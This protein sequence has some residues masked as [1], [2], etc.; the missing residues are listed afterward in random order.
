M[1]MTSS[2]LHFL[3]IAEATRLIA[4]RELSPV[5]L[6]EAYLQRIALIDSQLQSFVTL[7][8]DLARQRAAA[9][10]AEIMRDGPR[11]RLHGIPYCLKDI[12]ETAGIRTTA[13]SKLLADRVPARD[14]VVAEKLAAAGGV[15]LGKTAT[16]EFAHGGPSW[17]VLFPPARNPWNTSHHPAGS[18]SGSGA[19]VA[20]GLAPATIG[21]DTGG[22]IRGPAAACGI[23]GIKPTYGLVSRRGVLP[24]CFS[25]DHVGPLAWTSEDVAILLSIVAGHDPADPG[26]ADVP[27]KDY[28]TGLDAGIAGLV[29]GVPWRWLEEEAPLTLETR[30]GFDAA[31]A[32]FRDLGAEI[33]AVEP[34]PMQLF[35]DAKKVIAM[36]ELYSIH[37]KDLKTRPEL[38]GDSLRYRIIAGGLIRAEDY[39]QA[40]RVRRD[41]AIALQQVFATIDLMLLPT[42]E[43]AEK[44]EPVPHSSLFTGPSYMTAFNVGGNPA[45]SVCSGF[46]ANGMPQSLQ[47]AGRLFDDG[48]VLRAGHA[49]EKATPWRDLRPV[50]IPQPN[51]AMA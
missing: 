1:A 12:V 16:W 11:G 47:I 19:A 38:F 13:Q 21:S 41:L 25:H 44:L 3:T 6:T 37:E 31:L 23:A 50:L 32:V 8:A 48:V 17:D 28:T 49:Y 26:S 33:R 42:G 22:S 18:S 30:A 27:A 5:E 34:P 15:L 2:E 7:T 4:Q 43:P 36:A 29:V 14:A 51:R 24:N 40:M 39:V 20:A 9:A 45:L 10:E 35:N 46:A